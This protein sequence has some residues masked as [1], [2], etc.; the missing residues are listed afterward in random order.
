MEQRRTGMDMYSTGKMELLLQARLAWRRKQAKAGRSRPGQA[1]ARQGKTGSGPTH[2]SHSTYYTVLHGAA[3]R[4]RWYTAST[5]Y[6]G[7]E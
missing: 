5:V 1:R 7:H 2:I 3:A 4:R 6:T